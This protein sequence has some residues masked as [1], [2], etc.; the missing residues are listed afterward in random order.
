MLSSVG[1][2]TGNI[3]VPVLA[4][5]VIYWELYSGAVTSWGA[6]YS[7]LVALVDPYWST[8]LAAVLSVPLLCSFLLLTWLPWQDL[9]LVHDIRGIAEVLSLMPLEENGFDDMSANWNLTSSQLTNVYQKR[10]FRLERA[11]QGSKVKLRAVRNATTTS[12]QP[13]WSP[14]TSLLNSRVTKPLSAI[15]DVL[16][17]PYLMIKDHPNFVVLHPWLFAVWIICL[18]VLMGMLAWIAA[19][20]NALAKDA[21][22]DDRIPFPA[23]MYLLVGILLQ[24]GTLCNEHQLSVI[25]RLFVPYVALTLSQ[26][27][28]S[29]TL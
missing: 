9:G 2:V 16:R 7:W 17:K 27:S 21:I 19:S 14:V 10:L 18:F 6:E 13:P 1:S 15:W 22:W 26:S 5:Y 8:V 25:K 29:L 4:N 23:N 28:L 11:D 20:L 24:V 3:L 12:S